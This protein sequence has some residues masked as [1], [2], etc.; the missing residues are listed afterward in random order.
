MLEAVRRGL[1]PTAV[2]T[3]LH[4]HEEDLQGTVAHMQR[5]AVAKTAE[6]LTYRTHKYLQQAATLP[7][8]RPSPPPQTPVLPT[9]RTCLTTYHPARLHTIHQ[10][11]HRQ[12]MHEHHRHRTRTRRYARATSP[13]APTP[14]SVH[15]YRQPPATACPVCVRQRLP[16]TALPC[17]PDHRVCL[18]AAHRLTHC[19]HCGDLNPPH[20][21]RPATPAAPPPR[22]PPQSLRATH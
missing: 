8:N 18:G 7:S 12:G 19:P 6:Q 17:N 9:V 11:Q 20:H 1:V 10:A 3:L 4:T 16:R 2:Y 14:L 15:R 22:Q 21:E 5:T 13:H